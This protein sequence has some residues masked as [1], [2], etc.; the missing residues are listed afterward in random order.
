MSNIDLNRYTEFV[1]AVTSEPSNHTEKFVERVRLIEQDTAINP[2]LLLTASVGLGSECGEFTE[3]VKKMMF[4]GKP[5]TAENIYH[6]KREL[7]DIIWYWTNAC[8][9]L[10]FDPNDVIA[11]NVEKLKARYP[12]GEFS[13]YNS[14]VRRADDL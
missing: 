1:A 12:G 11:E 10:G 13:V 8:R 3:I 5:A 2:S 7:G 9:A 14:E 6:M 4:Q